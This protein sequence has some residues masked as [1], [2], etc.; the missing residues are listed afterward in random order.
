MQSTIILS[1]TV[2]KIIGVMLLVDLQT[3]F[4]RCVDAIEMVQ[5]WNRTNE[6][7]IEG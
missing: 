2:A 4:K 6:G 7:N 1:Y 5:K 3:L